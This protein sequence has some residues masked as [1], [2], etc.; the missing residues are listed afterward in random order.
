MECASG[1][2][3]RCDAELINVMVFVPPSPER[4]RPIDGADATILVTDLAGS[5]VVRAQLREVP[6]E[7]LRRAHD[8]LLTVSLRRSV[9]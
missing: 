6:A 9:A 8:S 1:A 2:S 4:G 3:A 5:T 7:E